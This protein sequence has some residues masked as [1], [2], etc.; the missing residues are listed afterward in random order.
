MFEQGMSSSRGAEK[1]DEKENLAQRPWPW[2]SASL[3]P[4][5]R[6]GVRHLKSLDPLQSSSPRAYDPFPQTKLRPIGQERNGR[7]E[8]HSLEKTHFSPL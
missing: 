6:A 2:V 4:L 7:L 5:V 1:P 3:S 8:S